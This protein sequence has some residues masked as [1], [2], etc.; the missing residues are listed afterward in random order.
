MKIE[1]VNLKENKEGYRG[2][3]EGKKKNGGKLGSYIIVSKIKERKNE[4]SRK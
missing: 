2:G 1:A 3:L 4:F